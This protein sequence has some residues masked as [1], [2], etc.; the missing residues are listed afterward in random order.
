MNEAIERVTLYYRSGSSDK[1]YQASIECAGEGEFVVNFA[2]G[3]RG[4]TLKTGCKTEEPV[5]YEKAKKVFDKLVKSK[6]AKGYSPGEG[7]TPYAGTDNEDRD[8]GV[9]CQLLNAVDEDQLDEL[10]ENPDF[11]MQEKFD[12]RRMLVRKHGQTIVGINRRGLEVGLPLTIAEDAALIEEDFLIDGE[13]VGDKLHAFDLLEHQGIDV[14]EHPYRGRFGRLTLILAKAW[15]RNIRAVD[16]AVRPAEKRAMLGRMRE[17]GREGV[18]FKQQDAPYSPGRPNSGGDQLKFKFRKT[19]SCVVWDRNAN[20]RSVSLVLYSKGLRIECGNVAIPPNQI[21][22]LKGSVVEVRY[23]YA[24]PESHALFQ[25]VFLGV[26]QDIP[27][28]ECLLEQLEYKA[29]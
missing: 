29:A 22:P 1:V 20:K 25:P 23:L 19:A 4:S 6:E 14:R 28:S 16:M 21:V 12:G 24:M 26:R 2:Y 7:G 15:T 5:P 8:T 3:R 10:I 17:N 9:C 11:Y 18:V 13:A 27:E